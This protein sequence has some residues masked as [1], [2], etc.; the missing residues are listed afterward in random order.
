[1]KKSL[2]KPTKHNK[3]NK[4]KNKRN[5]SKNK[6]NKNRRTMFHFNKRKQN[7][8]YS[9]TVNKQLITLKTLPR[10]KLHNC[11]IKRAYEL[12]EPLEIGIPGVIYGKTCFN[13][14]TSEAKDFLLHNLSANKHINIDFIVP[15]KQLQSNCWFNTM[16]V[17]FFISDKGR[18]FFHFLRQL[19]IEGKQLNG[20]I[21][22]ENIRNAF[23]LLNFGI[24]ASLTGNPFAYELNTNAIIHKLYKSIPPEY[25]EHHK[26]IT[27]IN[28]PGNPLRYY[29]SIINYLA[30]SPI[31]LVFVS[32]ANTDWKHKLTNILKQ[33]KH[34]PHIIAIEIYKENANKVNK[35]LTFNINEAK[36][37]ID[38]AAIID[39]SKQH[40]CATITCEGKEMSYDG[41]SHHPLVPFKWKD[42][43]N[44]NSNWGF[45]GHDLEWNFINCYQIL[46][47][48]RVI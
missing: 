35:P 45:K 44:N 29:I 6:S 46:M 4:S 7:S 19:M 10:E 48:Y 39:I 22:P 18:K 43:I 5:S 1:M 13:Y 36:Y 26:Y 28:N 42:Q 9:P 25:K 11:N 14:N 3:H 32:D 16:F 15:P 47:Y 12:K 37:E 24:D 31:L 38:S 20:E 2:K 34:L 41:M 23:A 17:M 40:F 30:G 27:D 21:I 8:S 33:N